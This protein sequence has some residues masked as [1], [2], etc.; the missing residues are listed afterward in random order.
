MVTHFKGQ[1]CSAIREYSLQ[2]A[3][4][5]I[6]PSFG[7]LFG[8][9]LR[10]LG[11]ATTGA[12]A[13]MSTLDATINFSG[14]YRH[15]RI[16]FPRGVA[17]C[18]SW[19]SSIGTATRYRLDS[20][21]IEIFHTRLWGSHN[22][23]YSVYEPRCGINHPLPCSIKIKERVELYVYTPSGSSWAVLRLTLPF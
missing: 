17:F 4:R 2:L 19:V 9:K 10:D 1:Q 5:S 15:W 16:A 3:T 20:P 13:I 14:M 23:I 11:V 18:A 12:S 22:L 8:D 7:L 6:E 21:G